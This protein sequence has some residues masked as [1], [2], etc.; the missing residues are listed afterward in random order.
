MTRLLGAMALCAVVSGCGSEGR[1]SDAQSVPAARA[2]RSGGRLVIGVQQEPERLSDILNATATTDLV[3]NLLFAKF[4][5]Y[6]A[7]LNLVPDMIEYIPTP[8]NGGISTDHLTY[9]YRLREGL[10]WHDGTALTSADVAFT[11]DIIMDD[12]IIVES[13]EG[14]DVVESVETPDSRTVVFHLKNPYPDFVSETFLEESV[15]PRHLLSDIAPAKF[16]LSEFHRAPVG[17]G[18]FVFKEWAP[19]SH[20]V[21]T[22]NDAYY[23]EGPYLDEIVIKF[24]P[25]ENAL[26]VQLKTGEIDVYDNANLTFVDQASG[27][28]NV[29]TYATPTLMYEHLDLNTENP[30][31]EDRRVRKA[32]GFATNRD[33]IVKSVYRGWAR[34]ASLDEHPSSRYFN[35]A[36]A[37][38]VRY[39]P[40][41]AR[42]LLREA[43]WVDHDGD[44][45]L[46]NGGRALAL[47]LTAT[48]GNPDR[49]KT[50][51]LLQ[52]QYR[53]IGIDLKIRNYN[54]TVLYG[55]YE[56][57]GVL[58]RGKFDI[59]MYAWLSS[60]EPA[61]KSALYASGS[62]PPN[63]Q[64][65]PR[66][67][68]DQLTDLLER[69]ARE[70][71]PETRVQLYHRASDILVEEV[72]VIP[73][74]WYTTVD[75]CVVSLHN[76]RPNPTQSSDAWNANTWY[77]ADSVVS[78]ALSSR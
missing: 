66:I 6:D 50:E 60:P 23:G 64:N 24:V 35:A 65:H 43:G 31:L 3:C 30:I 33:E 46:D 48:A 54:P 28:P 40:L 25:D 63:G 4:V 13:R 18:S 39:D 27:I 45:I 38:A 70:V 32:L 7:D 75:L 55:S 62:V 76:Y 52:S 34:V 49:E 2:P 36:A 58:K 19:G 9:I 29:K 15:L 16:H 57:G 20:I 12:E 17:S 51:I 74:F 11:Y 72:P 61:T 8:G 5:R 47:T 26:L 21:L 59:A 53:D 77:L 68:H 14:W 67:R 78:R 71:D 37:A 56:D 69:G 44:G 73:L 1:G 41:Q 42:K 22:R 10:R